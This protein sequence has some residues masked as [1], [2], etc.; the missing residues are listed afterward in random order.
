MFNYLEFAIRAGDEFLAHFDGFVKVYPG[1]TL[2]YYSASV[3][4]SSDSFSVL[5]EPLGKYFCFVVV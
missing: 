4:F 3:D 5:P 2:V 1:A